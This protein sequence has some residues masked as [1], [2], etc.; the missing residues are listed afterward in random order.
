MTSTIDLAD[1]LAPAATAVA[2]PSATGVVGRQKLT[3]AV[4]T[5]TSCV[6]SSLL[7][8]VQPI[9]G[10]LL[11]PRAGG[12][13]SLWNTAMVFFQA[14]LLAG[15]LV[16][17]LG[18]T[19]LGVAR[20]RY[21]HL[22]LLALPLLVLPLAVPGDWTLDEGTNPIFATLGVLAVMVGLPFLALATS[23]PTL[24][25]W[26]AATNHP[27]AAD[28][29]FLYAAGNIGSLASLLAYPLV[30]ERHLGLGAQTRL[31]L[32][33]YVGFV[34]LTAACALLLPG[35]A[36][37]VA[38][39]RLA[40]SAASGAAEV[41]GWD[42]RGRWVLWAFVPSAL[43][44]GTTRFLTTDIASFPLLWILP[45]VLYLLSYIVAFGGRRPEKLVAVASKAVAI[46]VIPLGLTLA[47]RVPIGVALFLHLSWL[48]AAA[49]LAHARLSADRP[50][51]ARLTEFYS[52][53][54][55]GGVL[56]G[57]FTALVAPLVFTRVWEYPLAIVAAVALGVSRS[58][59]RGHPVLWLGAF[60]ALGFAAWALADG[61][62]Q[63]ATVLLAVPPVLAYSW[64][65]SSFVVAIGLVLFIGTAVASDTVLMRD[66]SFFG[67]YAV[68]E[69]E[70][71]THMLQMGTTIH[72]S[73]RPDHPDQPT[74]YY[75][76]DGPL[77][78]VFAGPRA[79]L[80]AGLIG[81]GAGEIAA[82][83]QAGDTFT[84]F[85]IDP[86]VVEI[87]SDPEM[88]TYLSDTDADVDIVVGDGRL[89]LERSATTFDVLV[90][91]AFSS[92]AIPVHLL[93]QEAVATYLDHVT[94][95]GLVMIHISNRYFQLAPTIASIADELGLVA[96]H[97]SYEPDRAAF[98]TGAA[99]SSWVAIGRTSAVVD[100]LGPQW[101]PITELGPL[102]TDDYSNIL[103]VLDL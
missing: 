103:N 38:A 8:L 94:D 66:R 17:H 31:F 77:G 14:V 69:T 11:L 75:H 6:G 64:R 27:N 97:Q 19:R 98:D 87:A 57:G 68:L 65:R 86:V 49:L 58:T 89:E 4:F 73:Q 3:A 96:R 15:Y 51:A 92:D 7:F 100:E 102:W 23:S 9:V 25:R 39:A 24:Q 20:H 37:L 63:L 95:D 82:Y 54:S 60:I 50:S 99:S 88:F 90:V 21:A 101:T 91:D 26:F 81:L 42:R 34:A 41:I 78:D 16:A 59:R 13:V 46:G 48:F 85:E 62:V 28:P 43:L 35:R 93:T 56:G 40:R 71:G 29:Y 70:D 10:R 32:W 80:N 74:T 30:I 22:L 55:L 76:P 1:P 67:T 44:L 33:L 45:L 12:T 72:G 53:I 2:G 61:Q 79:D 36:D 47:G 83:G 5:L 52:W 18:A 84:Y